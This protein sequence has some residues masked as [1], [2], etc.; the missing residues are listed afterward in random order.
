MTGLFRRPL[1]GGTTNKVVQ[2]VGCA[3]KGPLTAG[4][5]RKILT[6]RK[7]LAS[8]LLFLAVMLA[9]LILSNPVVYNAGA[10]QEILKIQLYKT[11]ELDQGYTHDDPY[12]YSKGPQFWEWTL[13]RWFGSPWMLAFALLSLLAGCRWGP[14]RLLNR[15]TTSSSCS[16]VA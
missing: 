14:N 2:K 6:P 9:A 8:G 1:K 11:S 10:R 12:Y 5:L 15:L 13:T 7:T 16:R 4:L 3:R